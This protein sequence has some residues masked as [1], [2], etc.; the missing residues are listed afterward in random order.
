MNK[1]ISIALYL[2]TVLFAFNN[3]SFSQIIVVDNPPERIESG[4]SLPIQSLVVKTTIREQAAVTHIEQEFYN[5][6]STQVEG[7]YILPIPD[8]ASVS[9][10]TL[11]INGEQV[12]GELLD[13][14][15]A[16]K[17]Y[18]DIVSKLKDPGILSY[19]GKGL[20][21]ARIFPIEAK[22]TKKIE[23]RYEEILPFDRGVCRYEYALATEQVCKKP[24]D[25]IKFLI[26]LESNSPIQN[27]YSPSHS[28]SVDRDTNFDATVKYSDENVIPES[29]FQ[30][31]FSTS[32]KKIGMNLLSYKEK[33]K[34]GFFLL[35]AAPEIPATDEI[36]P[37]DVVLVLDT[38]GSMKSGNKIEQAKSALEYCI[39]SLNGEDRFAIV[40]F[41]DT[42]EPL[43]KSLVQADKDQI[44]TV[45]KRIKSI[46]AN[47]GTNIE[48][49]LEKAFEFVSEKERPA[50][51]LFLTDGLPT[52]GERDVQ[53][54]LKHTKT[55]NTQ[56]SRVFAFG[57]GYDVNTAL[58]DELSQNNKGLST[59]VKPNED[60]EVAVSS[61]Y[62]KISDPVL[63]DLDLD[64]GG[65]EVSKV[66]PQ[67]LPD[68]FS[69]SQ[70]V[71]L[72]RYDEGG[73]EKVSLR[74][75]LR[76]GT[77]TVSEEFVFTN[78]NTRHDFIPR[79]WASR[80]IGYLMSQI[81]EK[82]KDKELIEEI[83]EL[84]QTYG[85]LTQYTSFLVEE[86]PVAAAPVP[87]E[88]VERRRERILGR[89]LSSTGDVLSFG[90]A[91]SKESVV[92][93]EV[94]QNQL[95]NAT[96]L[97][98]QNVQFNYDTEGVKR[99]ERI[100]GI[101]YAGNQAFFQR[102]D[103]WI[104]TQFDAN[105]TVIQVKPF[106]DAYFQLAALSPEISK[107]LSLGKTVSFVLNGVM[108]QIDERGV[109]RLDEQQLSRLK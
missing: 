49:A 105:Q 100:G 108:V 11:E 30:L 60:I 1:A 37:K 17:V 3:P 48:G 23:I 5:P 61:M 71:V 62:S 67:N 75:K 86:S 34:A 42:V 72:G 79:L 73:S 80:R 59:Y 43:M 7:T 27:I 22:K 97:S 70:L 9:K 107:I 15:K 18:Q 104:S 44:E 78:D 103:Q 89:A 19:S 50:Y 31:I 16:E 36:N 45:W 63:A 2:S 58:L 41:S 87:L 35:L 66:Y 51:I 47:G 68:L 57:V 32:N 46:D 29:N 10:F 53:T 90:A 93:S 85:I 83:V 91:P 74:G 55:W 69:G 52:I 56:N 26:D 21:Q 8:T 12:K 65:I 33:N 13:K 88:E 14:N 38:S 102:G 4:T 25:F 99:V 77:H 98:T 84:S 101:R 76:G 28:I 81:R 94:V 64:F 6:H 24:I 82:G 106:S 20:I 96:S 54:I 109:E 40:T 95:Q 92:A 39:R